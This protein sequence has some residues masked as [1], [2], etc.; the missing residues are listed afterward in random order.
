MAK[1]YTDI[2][3]ETSKASRTSEG[4]AESNI[5]QIAKDKILNLVMEKIDNG[6]NID[7]IVKL[8]EIYRNIK[9]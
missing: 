8:S 4:I 2:E 1:N 5:N 3:M 6:S 7:Y 9:Q